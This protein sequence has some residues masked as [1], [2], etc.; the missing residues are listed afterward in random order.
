[1]KLMVSKG[2]IPNLKHVGIGPCEHYIFGK[3]KKVSFSKTSKTSKVERL[4][5]VHTNVWGPTLVKSLGGSQY[6]V[7]FIDDSTRKVWVYFLKI[8][9][10]CFL[11]LKSGKRRLRL[12]HV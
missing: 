2:K 7:T 12:K 1:M 10:M 11:C 6:Y 8:N 9:L 3:Q 4:Q 5:L